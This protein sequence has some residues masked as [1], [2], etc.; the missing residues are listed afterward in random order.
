VAG[1]M[2]IFGGPS[3][4]DREA[5]NKKAQ[6]DWEAKQDAKIKSEQDFMHT[7]SQVPVRGTEKGKYG[8]NAEHTPD[9][10]KSTDDTS[11]E[12]GRTGKM[13]VQMRKALKD[14]GAL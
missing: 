12:V 11:T 9:T 5:A 1:L 7:Q 13:S 3:T 6:A 4:A 2:D 14:A 10:Y 8:S